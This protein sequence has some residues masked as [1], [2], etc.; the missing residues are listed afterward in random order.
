M[1]SPPP[2][3]P[4]PRI[5]EGVLETVFKE[6]DVDLGVIRDRRFKHVVFIISTPNLILTNLALFHINE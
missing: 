1:H 6:N 2:L 5:S 3:P 4:P